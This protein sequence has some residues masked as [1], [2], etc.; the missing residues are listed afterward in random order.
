MANERHFKPARRQGTVI[1]AIRH[2]LYKTGE[3]IIVGS[4]TVTDANGEQTLCGADPATVRGVA[5]Q[6]AGSNP[7]YEVANDSLVVA[8]T[9]VVQGIS[10]ALA[11]TDQEFSGAMYN[12]GAV[13]APLQTHINTQYGVV[14]LASGVWV[15]DETDTVNVVVEI[16]DIVEAQG[17]DPGFHLFKFLDSVIEA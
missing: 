17:G 11:D 14:K 5:M 15:I 16:T 4:L 9:G 6:K 8:R 12:A 13:V 10:V 7:G 2:M 1:P 3:A